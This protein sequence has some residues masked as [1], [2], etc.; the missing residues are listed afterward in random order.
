MRP[1]HFVPADTLETL[2]KRQRN[3]EA[4]AQ[5]AVQSYQ[6]A[7]TAANPQQQSI[8]LIAKDDSALEAEQQP[9][10]ITPS[11]P[12]AI[13]EYCDCC[14]MEISEPMAE[15]LLSIAHMHSVHDY[16][17]AESSQ[18]QQQQSP[19]AVYALNERNSVGYRMLVKSGWNIERGLGVSEQGRRRPVPARRKLDRAGIGAPSLARN[20]PPLPPQQQ[21]QPLSRRERRQQQRQLQQQQQETER[22]LRDELFRDSRPNG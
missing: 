2:Q 1:V 3:R 11:T 13:R 9:Q 12:L 5:Q 22:R 8:Q 15:H 16:Y 6:Y 4:D 10:Q 20:R 14:K 17:A 19:P 7:L 21:Q 18:E